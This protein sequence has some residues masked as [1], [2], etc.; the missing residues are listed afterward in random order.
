MINIKERLSM[1][2]RKNII[3][4]V[5]IIIIIIAG[6]YIYLNNDNINTYIPAINVSEVTDGDGYEDNAASMQY[7]DGLYK[8]KFEH[9][10]ILKGHMFLNEVVFQTEENETFVLL[11][12][13]PDMDP[14]N[15]IPEAYIVPTIKD[16]IM[17]I[18]V[19]VDEDFRNMLENPLNIIWGSTYQNF[20]TYDFSTEYKTGIYVNTVYDNDTER[21]RIGGNDANIFVGDATLED[22]QTQN[23]DGITGVFLK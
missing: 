13:T 3:I 16:D 10:G 21:F 22:A 12:I 15:E 17:E 19:F 8:V 6:V 9:M 7:N 1:V 4:S 14:K 23:M 2:S 11:R 18:N 5:I 20:K